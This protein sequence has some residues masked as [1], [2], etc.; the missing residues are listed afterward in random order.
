MVPP[1]YSQLWQALARVVRSWSLSSTSPH[2]HH[3]THYDHLGLQH[4][5]YK[6]LHIAIITGNTNQ[7]VREFVWRR[8]FCHNLC[9]WGCQHSTTIQA[10]GETFPQVFVLLLL[11]LLLFTDGGETEFVRI[12]IVGVHIFHTNDGYQLGNGDNYLHLFFLGM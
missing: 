3:H 1:T 4:V 5:S 2:H 11:L 8:S 12:G 9:C 7:G 6:A 10:Y